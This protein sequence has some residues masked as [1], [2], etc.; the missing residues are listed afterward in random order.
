MHGKNG[1]HMDTQSDPLAKLFR[2]NASIQEEEREKLAALLEPYV[3]LGNEKDIRSMNF[4]PAFLQL[5][6]VEKLEIIFLSEKARALFFKDGKN[7]GL[8]QGDIISLNAMPSGSVKSSLKK[9]AD[10]KKVVQVSTGKYIIPNYRIHE[11]FTKYFKEESN[12]K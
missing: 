10:D 2:D 7:E 1:L 11:L 6:N 4:K 5:V 8:G 9:L 12:E 3:V